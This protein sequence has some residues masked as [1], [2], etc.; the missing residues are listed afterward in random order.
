MT[1]IRLT[2][3]SPP[4][5][6][7]QFADSRRDFTLRSVFGVAFAFISP[8]IALYVIFTLGVAAAG[9]SFWWAFPVVLGGQLL[10]ALMFGELSSRWPEEGGV[11]AWT[12]QLV[13][14]RLAWVTGW[15]YSWTLVC[16]NAAAAFAASAFAAELLGLTEAG[17][18]AR[19]GLATV[20]MVL[21][22]IVNSVSRRWLKAFITI[23]IVCEV[24]GSLYVGT[25]LLMF[26]RVNDW[27]VLFSGFTEGGTEFVLGPFLAAVALAGW[28]LIGFESAADLAAE[29][30]KPERSVPFAQIASLV[31][32]ALTVMYTGAAL[33][34]A[35]PDLNA[36]SGEG[37]D[38]I[39]DTVSY[40]LGPGVVGPL[41]ALVCVG[42]LAGIA[43]VSAALS[44]ALHAM[45]ARRT[46]PGSSWLERRSALEQQPRNALILTSTL[47]VLILIASV[48]AGFYDVMISMSTGGFYV[49]FL[50]P[51]AAMLFARARRQWVPGVFNL[52]RWSLGINIGA[53]VW[54]CFEVVNI[55]WPRPMDLPWYVEWGCVLMFVTLAVLGV[56]VARFSRPPASSSLP[57]TEETTEPRS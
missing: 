50:I 34:L 41:S 16:L 11:Y 35:I 12:R 14:E 13:G 42:F 57:S 51:V 27:S 44:R 24:V 25:V 30:R 21:A 2:N 43:A 5:E 56:I 54:L 26:H 18:G 31:L 7:K 38:A 22:T 9:P 46:L 4:S 1:N 8:I 37:G 28:A 10:V 49:A 29:V 45:A 39:L 17:N 19:L 20:F 15:T 48:T 23:S 55:A 36:L 33:I 53:F 3:T 6:S 40:A 32:V 47:T 52:R